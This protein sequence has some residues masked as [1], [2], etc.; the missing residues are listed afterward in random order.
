MVYTTYIMKRKRTFAG[1]ILVIVVAALLSLG[2]ASG[3]SYYEAEA[4]AG[5]YA[6]SVEEASYDQAPEAPSSRG[7]APAPTVAYSSGPESPQAAEDESSATAGDDDAESQQEG[8]AESQQERRR[9]RVYAAELGLE[10][11]DVEEAKNAVATLAQDAGGFVESSDETSI[12]VRVP[13]GRF[14][15]VRLAIERLGE[16]VRRVV[17]SEDVTDRYYDMVGRIE[18]AEATK[19]RLEELLEAT[20]D[21]DEQIR[22]VREI[23][24]LTEQIESFRATLAALDRDIAYSLI[25]VRLQP[26]LSGANGPEYNPFPWIAGLDLLYPTVGDADRRVEVDLPGFAVFDERR[27]VRAESPEGVRFRLGATENDPL[28]DAEFWR[29]ALD[30]YLAP[31]FAGAQ[32]LDIGPFCGVEFLGPEGKRFRYVVLVYPQGDQLWVAEVYYPNDEAHDAQHERV[33][34]TLEEVRL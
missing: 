6:P 22:I 15:E 9:L 17:T 16:V 12:A 1:P 13:A 7:V 10:V 5:Y 32:P 28:G 14:D 8:D 11:P 30:R 20:D 31:R 26:I 4:P 25:S 23:N 29:A 19:A 33:A 27:S 24:R 34:E 18:L 2:C 3:A 21:P